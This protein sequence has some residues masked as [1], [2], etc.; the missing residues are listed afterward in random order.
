MST[1]LGPYTLGRA[2]LGDLRALGPRVPDQF[3]LGFIARYNNLTS[4]E[5][6]R[7]ALTVGGVGK[8]IRR[9]TMSYST[10]TS[11][12]CASP[13]AITIDDLQAGKAGEYLV[14][15]DLI[16]KGY[17]AFLSEQGLSY[18]VVID[19]NGK[20]IRVQVKTTRDPK[21]VPQRK[22]HIPAYLFNIRQMGKGGRRSYT[23]D[24]VDLFALVALDAREI[25]YFALRDIKQSMSFRVTSLCGSYLDEVRQ[26]KKE[27][28]REMLANGN[29]PNQIQKELGLS[30]ASIFRY[31][32]KDSLHPSGRYLN[33]F[34]IEWAI[35]R[36]E[37]RN[38]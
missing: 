28:A 33:N 29:S 23:E 1:K 35:A 4:Y 32:Q 9:S 17:V 24:I 14:C 13:N 18:D 10:S 34:S 25:G 2:Y 30:K 36:W 5:S 8:P 16:L 21:P 20:L 38:D 31:L 7:T 37:Q 12:F 15:A 26:E 3:V 22:I 27:R 11:P 6:P 19:H